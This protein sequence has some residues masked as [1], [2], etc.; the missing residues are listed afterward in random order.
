MEGLKNKPPHHNNKSI[1]T[2]QYCIT[3][4][5]TLHFARMNTLH[6]TQST[7]RIHKIKQLIYKH[8]FGFLTHHTHTLAPTPACIHACAKKECNKDDCH[9]TWV[10]HQPPHL[11]VTPVYCPPTPTLHH[12]LGREGVYLP[13]SL[14]WGAWRHGTPGSQWLFHPRPENWLVTPHE[15]WW[16]PL[17]PWPNQHH[18]LNSD[19]TCVL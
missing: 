4:M 19:K 5:N 11:S 9:H 1:Y 13:V 6:F 14:R 10:L 16:C 7:K 18:S 12:H 8:N 3:R 2:A 17:W 15:V